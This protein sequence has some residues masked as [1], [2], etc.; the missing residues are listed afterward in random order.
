MSGSQRHL[1]RNERVNCSGM[2]KEEKS[3]VAHT[4]TALQSSFMTT[5]NRRPIS[6][7]TAPKH[8]GALA[9]CQSMRNERL[10]PSPLKRHHCWACALTHTHTHTHTHSH[11]HTHNAHR[12]THIQS[13]RHTHTGAHAHTHTH[14]HTHTHP[15]CQFHRVPRRPLLADSS[16]K[17]KIKSYCKED[18]QRHR[19]LYSMSVKFQTWDKWLRCLFNI[20]KQTWLPGFSLHL[21]QGPPGWQTHPLP[22]TLQDRE[23]GCSSLCSPTIL[24]NCP[25]HLWASWMLHLVLLSLLF[26]PLT[27]LL[28]WLCSY[29]LWTLPDIPASS[30]SFPHNLQ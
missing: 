19:L 27:P 5:Q 4:Q 30:Y 15:L 9:L 13:H 2:G 20:S 26:L 14:T 25:L 21:L 29:P 28:T 1:W 8:K 10:V 16:E 17:S 7:S 12:H 11:R 22:W 18:S 6:R 24:V 23:P 3:E